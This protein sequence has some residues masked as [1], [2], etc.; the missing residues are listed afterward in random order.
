MGAGNYQFSYDYVLVSMDILWA[1]KDDIGGEGHTFKTFGRFYGND[2]GD[3]KANAPWNWDDPDDGAT[4]L[5]QNWS[6]PAHMVDVHLNGLLSNEDA[7]G[8]KSDIYPLL[9]LDG[10][11]QIN[12]DYWRYNNAEYSQA[13]E[14]KYGKDNAKMGGPVL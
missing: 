7:F 3:S 5:G 10:E 13:Y 1:R 9:T 12:K 4:F 2:Y 8:G 14:A 11:R 6:D